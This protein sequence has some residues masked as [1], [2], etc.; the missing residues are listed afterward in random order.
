VI[1]QR[2]DA[3]R[4]ILD[5]LAARVRPTMSEL[6]GVSGLSVGTGRR[7]LLW[8]EREGFVRMVR[9]GSSIRVEMIRNPD[10]GE[11]RAAIENRKA[12]SSGTE[13]Q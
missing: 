8:L 3:Q 5:A 7:C 4:M 13:M 11:L 10:D 1:A 6:S 9:T 12:I 2:F